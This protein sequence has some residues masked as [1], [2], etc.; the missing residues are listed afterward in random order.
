MMKILITGGTGFIGRN[1]IPQ[2]IKDVP[3]TELVLL[4]RDAKKANELFADLDIAV[5]QQWAEIIDFNPDIVIHL[6]AMSCSRNDPEVIRPLIE[7]NILY[8]VNLLETLSH[9]DNLRLFVNTGSFAEYRLGCRKI[10]N[11]YLYS[12]TKTA[13][14]AFLDYYSKLNGYK[15]ITAV[16]Y[17]VYGGV[18]TVKRIMD[19]M[20]ESMDASF[21]VDMTLGEQLLDFIYVDDVASFYCHVA[22]HIDTYLTLEQGEE[23]HLGTGIGTSLRQVAQIIEKISGHHLNIHWGGRPYRERD[24]MYAVA[25]IARNM[26]LT[27]WKANIDLRNGIKMFLDNYGT[28]K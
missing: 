19:Y 11:A 10:D 26:E 18:P 25:P 12:T 6:A 23:F 16:P 20:M 22:Q 15:Y 8:G 24:T 4:C 28:D 13:F 21:P 17:S 2:L 3:K 14:R 27:G 7:S 1:L 5:A 9:C